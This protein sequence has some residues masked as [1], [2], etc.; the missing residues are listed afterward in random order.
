MIY[1]PS[2]AFFAPP[3]KTVS[4]LLFRFHYLCLNFRTYTTCK[5]CVQIF[6]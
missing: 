5:T 2:R 1:T 6:G 4:F 3:P